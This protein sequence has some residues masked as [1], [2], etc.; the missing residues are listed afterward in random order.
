MAKTYGTK[1]QMEKEGPQFKALKPGQYIAKLT[2][3]EIKEKQDFNKQLVPTLCLQFSP[4]EAN[5]R[6]GVIKDVEG[7]T[8]KPLSRKLFQDINK[9]SMGFRENFTIPSKYRSLVAALQDMDA[10]DDVPGPDELSVESA[11]EQIENFLGDYLV[12][13]VIVTEKKGNKRNKITDFQPVPEDFEPDEVTEKLAADSRKKKAAQAS[14]DEDED[15]EEEDD[16]EEEEEVKPKTAKASK[17]KNTR[18]P[19]F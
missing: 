16:V 5:S 9:V 4:Y 12:V 18:K 15:L 1:A 8:V 3:A 2:V 11:Y 7:T 14:D 10:N 17:S 13:T 6:S 19:L